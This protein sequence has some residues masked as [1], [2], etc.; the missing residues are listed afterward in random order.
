MDKT[1]LIIFLGNIDYDSRASNLYKS[2]CERGFKVKVVSFDWLTSGLKTQTDD[3]SIYKL[4]KGFL[5]LTYYLKFIIILS[6]N[7]FRSEAEIIFA[8]DIYTLPFAVLFAKFKKAKVFYDSREL[9]GYLAG[10]KKR[11][12]IQQIL[13]RVEKTFITK[14]YKIITTGKMDAEFLSKEYGVKNTIV[15]RNLPFLATVDSPFDFRTKYKLKSSDKIIL[16]Q[17]VILHGRGLR[18]IFDVISELENVILIIIGGGE[19]KNYY[20]QLA[21]E[22]GVDKKT[23]FLGKVNQKELLNYTAGADIGLALIENISLSYYYALPNKMFEY[24]LAGVPVLAS[25]FPQMKEIIG[26]YKVGI[27][28][29]PENRMELLTKLKEVLNN[30]V[31]RD[32]YKANC[33]VASYDLNWNKEIK[34]LFAVM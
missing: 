26:R 33:K 20:E 18:V 25:N 4:N 10:L 21:V 8:E 31:Q 32:Q 19:H 6:I 11:K 30:E 5:S 15:I 12:I 17:G 29:D 7:L 28:V 27:Y 24:I 1:V 9:Y 34:K 14:A 22:K 23:I 2:L 16:Y 3:V 13:K